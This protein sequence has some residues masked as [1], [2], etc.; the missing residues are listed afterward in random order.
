MED[1]FF[2]IDYSVPEEDR[3]MSI[4]CIECHEKYMPDVGMYWNA[5]DG[6]GPFDYKCC[7]C[8]KLVHGKDEYDNTDEEDDEIEAP[9]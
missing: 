5:N 2:F 7:K 9:Y 6:Y 8:G 3:T 4:V 1:C